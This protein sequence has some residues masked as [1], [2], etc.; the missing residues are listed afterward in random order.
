MPTATVIPNLSI[1]FSYSC[2]TSKSKHHLADTDDLIVR[3]CRFWILFLGNKKKKNPR[4][5]KTTI[6]WLHDFIMENKIKGEEEMTQVL[7]YVQIHAI[8][9]G[10]LD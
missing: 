4:N 6:G 8:M 10:L 9:K 1:S 5:I 2:P 3:L 7:F